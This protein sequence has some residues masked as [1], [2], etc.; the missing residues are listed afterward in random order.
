MV[1]AIGLLDSD[2]PDTF[3][4]VE[5]HRA[6]SRIF[7]SNVWLAV[8]LMLTRF[9]MLKVVSPA[10]PREPRV[11]LCRSV[12][13]SILFLAPPSRTNADYPLGIG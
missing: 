12:C 4:N 7:I 5:L 8:A 6:L 3:M 10:S 1:G 11:F 9:V 2:V 13:I